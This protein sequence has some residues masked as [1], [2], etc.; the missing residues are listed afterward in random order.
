MVRFSLF[1]RIGLDAV[2]SSFFN[3]NKPT[4]ADAI[5][6]TA[7]TGSENGRKNRRHRNRQNGLCHRQSSET[8]HNNDADA[9]DCV[10][11]YGDEDYY[12]EYNER[13][14]EIGRPPKRVLRKT[15]K[16]KFKL[17]DFLSWEERRGQYRMSRTVKAHAYNWKLQVYSRG[18]NYSSTEQ[19]YVSCYLHYF[20]SP[21]DKIAPTAKVTY[22][23]GSHETV[24]QLCDFAVDKNKISMSWGL[25]NFVRRQKAIDKNYIDPEDGSLMIEIDVQI[26]IDSKIVWYPPPMRKESTLRQLYHLRQ[27]TADVIFRLTTP[28]DYG[29]DE[30]IKCYKAHRMILALRAKILYELVCEEK[31]LSAEDNAVVV[32]LP[33]L[34][35]QTFNT[36]LEHIYTVKQPK[37]E[38]EMRAK[39]LLVAADRYHLTDLKLYAESILTD[40]FVTNKNAAELL[41]FADSHSCALLKEATLDVCVSGDMNVLRKTQG[42]A[43]IEESRRILSEVLNHTHTGCRHFFYNS[44]NNSTANDGNDGEENSNKK[45]NKRDNGNASDD[46]LN[47]L[48]VFSLRERLNEVNLSVDGSRETLIRR[49]RKNAVIVDQNDIKS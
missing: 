46:E 25:E 20:K 3:D 29:C 4:I 35:C 1:R 13:V 41:L 45:E 18:D 22:R 14:M 28:S 30:T 15:E 33:G 31:T 6:T 23:V 2:S 12:S 24:T 37:L 7:S 5:A 11:D 17:N 16:L 19:E 38:D 47:Q 36:M 9:E 42:W 10:I 40:K 44:N 48:D 32:D 49:L 21:N 43:R 39:K 26:A 34:D 8:P 27:E